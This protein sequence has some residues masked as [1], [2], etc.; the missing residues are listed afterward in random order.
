MAGSNHGH[1]F[2]TP[3]G[4]GR[5]NELPDIFQTPGQ[6]PPIRFPEALED[7]HFELEGH[8]LEVVDAGD[9]DTAHSTS[10][11]VPD[12]GLMIAGDGAAQVRA[13]RAVVEATSGSLFRPG[14]V[15]GS[16]AAHP[17]RVIDS[18]GE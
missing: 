2:Q 8:R 13:I 4:H 15:A 12:P 10:L 14:K 6:I 5:K 17:H 7:D 3:E 18:H 9:T 16:L 11:W 1:V